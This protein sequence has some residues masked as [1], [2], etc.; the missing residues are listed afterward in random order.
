V[1]ARQDLRDVR[2]H[3]LQPGRVRDHAGSRNYVKTG[4]YAL[5]QPL[6]ESI[7]SVLSRGASTKRRWGVDLAQLAAYRK[8]DPEFRLAAEAFVE[9]EASLAD[10]IVSRVANSGANS[11]K[12]GQRK[13]RRKSQT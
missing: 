4:S 11:V 2:S 8:R 10:P 3:S 9:S 5:A 6:K 12:R 13:R 7:P 1:A